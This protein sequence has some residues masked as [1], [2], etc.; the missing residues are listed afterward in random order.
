[1]KPDVSDK[2]KLPFLVKTYKFCTPSYSLSELIHTMT[3]A[4][5]KVVIL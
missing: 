3:D 2:I 4:S 5:G 1:M